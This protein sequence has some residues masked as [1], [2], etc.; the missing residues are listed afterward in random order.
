M[1]SVCKVYCIIDIVSVLGKCRERKNS[2]G[3]YSGSFH[4]AFSG[5]ISVAGVVHAVE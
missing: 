3:E 4:V 1:H 2:G 5:L